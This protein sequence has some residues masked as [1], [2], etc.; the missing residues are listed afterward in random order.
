M[1]RIL[2][3]FSLVMLLVLLTGCKKDTTNDLVLPGSTT[4][5]VQPTTIPVVSVTPSVTTN[6]TQNILTIK[7]Y[8]PF[9]EDS[10]YI[11]EGTG[12]EFAAMNV[13]TDFSDVSNNRIQT[14]TENGGTS[15]IK[16]VEIKDGKLSIITSIGESYYRDNLLTTEA[17]D[18][19]EVLLMEPL[20]KGTQWTLPDNSKRYIS[21]TDVKIE[22]P[23]GTYQAL[24]VMTERTDSLTMD[25]YA[26][27]VG[28]VKT[29]F[30]TGDSEI[31]S[32]L[33]EIKADTPYT[34]VVEF[35]YPNQ[36]EKMYAEQKTLTF[37]TNDI[38]STIIEAAIREEATKKSSLPLI[39]P[40][41]K[42]NSMYL[43]KDNIAYID[44]TKDLVKDMNA[45]AGYE[46]LILQSI[47]NTLGNYYGVQKVYISMD[48]KPYESG[49]ILLK[50][51]ET[52]TVNMDKVVR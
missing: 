4:P 19:S 34:Q 50:E 15:T 22:T 52:F 33:K 38:T 2:L 42:I 14:R 51:G 18:K 36:D 8:Y 20:V 44:F 9:H 45:G 32:T 7:D 12:N 29:V 25:Y 49:H 5:T 11:Y 6:P 21:N 40:N 24:E 35:Y 31:S 47:T 23:S 46:A 3:S 10:E 48:N 41:T 16:V 26:P 17:S 27:K 13:W 28:L 39:G 37:H 30:K 43:G 1:K